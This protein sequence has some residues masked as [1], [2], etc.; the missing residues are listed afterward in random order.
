M[1]DCLIYDLAI[2]KEI[3]Y[4][5][6]NASLEELILNTQEIEVLRHA[7]YELLDYIQ[8]GKFCYDTFDERIQDMVRM[9]ELERM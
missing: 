2:L 4:A 8:Y 5:L 1:K 9:L 3:E 6:E 7:A